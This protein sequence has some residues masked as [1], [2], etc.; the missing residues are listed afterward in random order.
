[1]L[2][3]IYNPKKKKF[4]PFPLKTLNQSHTQHTSFFICLFVW[5]SFTYL[6]LFGQWWNWVINL[7]VSLITKLKASAIES[8][9]RAVPHHGVSPPLKPFLHCPKPRQDLKCFSIVSTPQCARA[10]HPFPL[11]W[12]RVY[13]EHLGSKLAIERLDYVTWSI[14]ATRSTK[15]I[16]SQVTTDVETSAP[17]KALECTRPECSFF[18]PWV[19]WLAEEVSF[20][21]LTTNRL[22]FLFSAL[23]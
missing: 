11:C 17:L 3:F 19:S 9:A 13:R 18:Y 14:K 7:S 6:D 21:I 15:F 10:R 12:V 23:W 1:M 5:F 16:H 20:I 4:S 2:C 22:T 8:R